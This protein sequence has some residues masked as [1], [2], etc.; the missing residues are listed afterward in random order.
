MR[1]TGALP[2]LLQTSVLVHV[3]KQTKTYKEGKLVTVSAETV[4]CPLYDAVR[5]GNRGRALLLGDLGSGKS[6]LAGDLIL[7]TMERAPST[8]AILVPAKDIPWP[9]AAFSASDLMELLDA[10][11]AS[12]ANAASPTLKELMEEGCELLIVVDGLDELNHTLAVRLLHLLEHFS[13]QWSALQVVATARPVELVDYSFDRWTIIQTQALTE[14]QQLA[15][16]EAELLADNFPHEQVPA[17]AAEL[18]AILQNLPSLAAA[19]TTPLFIRLLYPKLAVLQGAPVDTRITLGDLLYDLVV[20]RLV[21]WDTINQIDQSSGILQQHYFSAEA[22]AGLLALLAQKTLNQGSLPIGTARALLAEALGIHGGDSFAQADQALEHFQRT[23]FLTRGSLI[24][25]TA[26][27]L[28]EMVAA[29]GLAH[30]W[31]LNSSH[32][33]EQPSISSWRAVSFAATVARRQG[34]ADVAAPVLEQYYPA[35]LAPVRHNIAAVAYIVTELLDPRS[36]KAV[37]PLISAIG[38]RPIIYSED[39]KILENRVVAQML[40]L[41]GQEGADW[42][43]NTYLNPQYP[44]P[45]NELVQF[46]PL[47]SQWVELYQLSANKPDITQFKQLIVPY[48]IGAKQWAPLLSPYLVLLFPEEYTLQDRVKYQVVELDDEILGSRIKQNLSALSADPEARDLILSHLQRK[49]KQGSSYLPHPQRAATLW[50]SLAPDGVKVPT[51]IIRAA[52]EGVSRLGGPW[53]Q[54]LVEACKARLGAECWLR[55]AYWH[56]SDES[57]LAAAGAAIVIHEAG[58]GNLY[59]LGD[60]LLGGLGHLHDSDKAQAVLGDM[61]SHGNT[62]DWRWLIRSLAEAVES[63]RNQSWKGIPKRR[64]RLLLPALA[65]LPDGPI[66]LA[67]CLAN[68]D[69]YTIPRNPE[70]REEFRQLLTG[71][72]G[73]EFVTTLAEQL[74]HI[75]PDR[76]WGAAAVLL[77]TFPENQSEALLSIVRSRASRKESGTGMYDWEG[78]CL[79]LVLGREPLQRLKLSL[80]GLSLSSKA[81]ALALLAKNGTPLTQDE[82]QELFQLSLDIGNGVL[83]AGP[84]GKPTLA[85]PE[86]RE[87]LLTTLE[88]G[89][90]ERAKQ[91][92]FSLLSYHLSDLNIQQEAKCLAMDVMPYHLGFREGHALLLRLEDEREITSLIAAIDSPASIWT[93]IC[94]ALI[95]SSLW[96]EVLWAILDDPEGGNEIAERGAQALL[97]FGRERPNQGRAIGQSSLQM[98]PDPRW[99]QS[100]WAEHKQW[101]VLLADEFAGPVPTATKESVLLE[102]SSYAYHGLHSLG[103]SVARAL[104]GRLPSIPEDLTSTPPL[105][106]AVPLAPMPNALDKPVVLSQ[107]VE[108]G[109]AGESMHPELLSL[110][111][112]VLWLHPLDAEEVT[113]IAQGGLAGQMTALA[114]RLC[115]SQPPAL[116]EALAFLYS[117]WQRN[118]GPDKK[119][120]KRLRACWILAR[121]QLVDP[122]ANSDAKEAYEMSLARDLTSGGFMHLPQVFELL[123]LR[124]KLQISEAR[125]LFNEFAEHS[126]GLHKLLIPEISH[127][128]TGDLE[129]DEK[130][131]LALLF[132]EHLERIEAMSWD[133]K[134]V[135]SVAVEAYFLFSFG[136]WSLTQQP[137]PAASFAFL[138]GIKTLYRDTSQQG[139]VDVDDILHDLEPLLRRVPQS[140]IDDAL[141]QGRISFDPSVR[142]F[143]KL[144]SGFKSQKDAQS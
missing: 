17:R 29:F 33:A 64:W 25:F 120:R 123:R 23:G 82:K 31:L 41:A 101:L 97:D 72:R 92:A 21:H 61:L 116:G 107:L 130:A 117:L 112:K 75:N 128:L 106:A 132:K 83:N 50:L 103:S 35:L 55:F 11:V 135:E 30:S 27:P 19:A 124:G 125:L 14:G 93:L 96:T 88:G 78:F 46:H 140:F 114:L 119:T 89:N 39:D 137:L 9:T 76:R 77:A 79:S 142:L 36:A 69:I 60:S 20:E 8:L 53:K 84:Q 67:A 5:T 42:L 37:L 2:A 13:N 12:N 16:L 58:N 65:T 22:K 28:A 113:L 40:L 56:L 131:E 43:F 138:K 44:L 81:F 105:E 104:V 110:I 38:P 141:A 3:T 45:E 91:A 90:P 68:L 102:L 34:R 10:Y 87:F 121:K 48:R 15:L 47:L 144:M 74:V 118:D 129:H 18:L 86:A 71:E 57:S 51:E 52:F 63:E 139:L 100:R 115:Y 62:D 6:T 26:Q 1:P 133:D 95:D 143:S 4:I 73:A 108:A 94:K 111:E 122:A 49:L 80:P 24:E 136:F 126:T 134:E 99:D 85:V 98:L 127:W 32:S 59:F 109:R 66:A 7:Q 70:I 54:G